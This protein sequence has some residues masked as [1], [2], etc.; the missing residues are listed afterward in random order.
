MNHDN[1]YKLTTN[2]TLANT[3]TDENRPLLVV[4]RLSVEF[5]SYQA[6]A[7]IRVVNEVSFSIFPGEILALVG[8]SGSGKSMIARSLLKLLPYPSA[9]HPTGHIWFQGKDLQK[10]PIEVLQEIRSKEISM[11]FQEPMSALNPLKT[12]GQQITEVILTHQKISKNTAWEQA[13]TLLEQVKIDTPEK[14]LQAYPHELSGG[15]RQRIVIAIAIANQPKIL[16]ADEPTTALDVTVQ[17]QI[18]ELLVELQRK[19]NMSILL[20]SHDLNLVKKFAQRVLVM[21]SGEIV[22]SA[23]T[24]T[25]FRCPSHPYTQMLIASEPS[26]FPTPVPENASPILTVAALNIRFPVYKGIFRRVDHYFHAVQAASFQI[27]TGESVGIVGESGSGKTSLAFAVLRLLQSEGQIL[28]HQQDLNQLNLRQVQPLRQKIQMVFQDP[29]GSLNPRFCIEDL[30]TEGL[31]VHF[32]GLSPEERTSKV[33]AVLEEVGLEG[34]MLYRYPHEFSGGQRQRI[35]IARAIILKPQLIVLDEPTSALD[36]S[37]QT[38]IIELLK[39]LQT[40]YQ[41]SYLF[42]SHDLKVIRALCHRVLVMKS[43]QIVESS[44]A[45]TLFTQPAHPYT[46][47]LLN[48]SLA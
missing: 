31:N 45:E 17:A 13:K 20:I 8:E 16:I 38:Q 37:L 34:D 12:I 35:A 44:D 2:H 26:G 46:Q 23:P 40:K 42:I 43:G 18:I 22:E 4:D 1:I 32:P 5:H 11:V 10:A 21:K 48:A 47:E 41:I 9:S 24:E 27:L 30:L 36:R 15:Q 28:F 33:Q 6:S 25:L 39:S 14:R 3:D 19:T 7:P 29:Y